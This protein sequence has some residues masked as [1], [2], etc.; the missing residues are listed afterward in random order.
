[1][2]SIRIGCASAFWG[3]TNT[4]A[5]QLVEKGDIDYLVS[6]YLSEITM[7]ILAAKRRRDPGAGYAEDFVAHALKP[8]LAEIKARGIRVISNAGGINPAACRDAL[9]AAAAEAG[10]TFKIAIVTGDDLMPE[11]ARLASAIEPMAGEGAMPQAPVSMNAYLG[12]PGIVAALDA[13]A[14]IVITGRCVDSA[15]VLAPLVHEFG[16]DWQDYDRLAAGSLAGHI[17]ECG[18]QCT[19]GNFTD[20]H[21]V[22]DGYAD[23]GFPIVEVA[24]DGAFVVTKP[25][26]TGGLVSCHTVAEQMLYEIGDPRA[27]LLPDVACD[28]TQVT[29]SQVGENRVAVAGARGQAP[30]ADYKISATYMDGYRCTAVFVVGGIE[31]GAKAHSAAMAILAKTE[32]LFAERGLGP[33]ADYD[34]AV[35][36]TEAMYGANARQA[37]AHS[38]EVVLKLAV[39]HESKDALALFTRELA[40]AATGMVPGVTGFFGG[41]PSVSPVIRLYSCFVPKAA[42][43][44]QVDIDATIAQVVIDSDGGF[45]RDSRAS[46]PNPTDDIALDDPVPVPLVRLALARSGDKGDAANIGVIARDPAYLP[47]LRAALTDAA[48]AD[49]FAHLLEGEVCHWELPG[50]HSMNF[51]LTRVLG[52]GGVAS[53]RADAQGKCLGQM[54]LDFP[55][56]V[57]PAIAARID[58]V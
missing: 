39:R 16:W 10:L 42:V 12:A 8:V 28:F 21:L 32:R 38:R 36:G 45:D 3:D 43:A 29:L 37:A 44:V 2:D 48:V 7:S 57:S 6:D 9:A 1:M 11:R 24:R 56:P 4:A 13:G 53:L 14:D 49:W 52:G 41:R 54:L 40:Q 18:C 19:G 51:L 58:T 33:Y 23:M 50:T 20:W 30:N 35:L 34:I 31:A 47:Y 22:A 27:Y 55:V 15:L 17:I 25:A 46:E 5:A 26:G